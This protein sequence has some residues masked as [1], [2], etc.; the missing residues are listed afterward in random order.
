MKGGI[1]AGYP[2]NCGK[3]IVNVSMATTATAA[4]DGQAD[5]AIAVFCAACAPG[6]SP[7]YITNAGAAKVFEAI[8]TCTKINNCDFSDPTVNTWSN[9]CE[10]CDTNFAWQY[11]NDNTINYSVCV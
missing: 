3:A 10:T 9:S 4:A 11:N 2:D 8:H 1:T 6:Y 7:G 5:T